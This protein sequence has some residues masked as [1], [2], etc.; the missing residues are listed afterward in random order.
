MI[1]ARRKFSN[2]FLK[3]EVPV[4]YLILTVSCSTVFFDT[5]Q[6]VD[7]HNL[8][9]VPKKL[10]GKW[11]V[12]GANEESL[13]TI[14]NSSYHIVSVEKVRIAKSEADTSKAYRIKENKIYLRENNFLNGYPFELLHDT[15]FFNIR[16]DDLIVLSDSVLLRKAWNCY[17]LNLKRKD[18][19]E[20]VFIQ[21]MKNKEIR[22]SYPFNYDI[23]EMRSRWNVAVLDSTRNDSTFFHAEFSKRAIEKVI[24]RGGG[25]IIY[26]LKPDSTFEIPH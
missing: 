12:K 15:I 6:P 10:Q 20:I 11:R 24:P 1:S 7:S 5:P 16:I 4:L 18:W 23:V 19:W 3:I 9:H 22:I 21:K 13:I 2:G 17:V 26:I 14:D 25:G 8:S